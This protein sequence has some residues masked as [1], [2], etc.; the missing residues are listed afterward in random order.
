MI[1]EVR[2]RAL[3]KKTIF[4]TNGVENKNSALKDWVDFSRSS[5][6]DFNIK[7]S[8]FI[9]WQNLEAEKALYSQGQYTLD[10]KYSDL[11]VEYKVWKRMDANAR[12]KHTRLYWN[13][14]VRTSDNAISFES[15]KSDVME[16]KLSEKTV[17]AAAGSDETDSD[18][19]NQS[20]DTKPCPLDHVDPDN[21]SDSISVPRERVRNIAKKARQLLNEENVIVDAPGV[22][23][24]KIV[25]S[26]TKHRPYF[27]E[28]G[29]KN[30]KI[31]CKYAMYK[32]SEFCS[33]ALA[34]ACSLNL[35]SNFLQWRTKKKVDLNLTALVK[36][37][38]PKSGNK[39]GVV[40][41]RKRKGGRSTGVEPDEVVNPF[42]LFL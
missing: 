25:A 3:I 2:N 12:Q 38:A 27:V 10:D 36:W 30:G 9:D 31:T 28:Y 22:S 42:G 4:T 29:Y 39:G 18:H 7:F 8:K 32:R 1:F 11:K 15:K 23:N 20:L 41:T 37:D 34:V 5:L 6:P 13:Q 21:L 35:T 17:S 16:E 24:T 40:G 14:K 33:H 26:Q 19:G